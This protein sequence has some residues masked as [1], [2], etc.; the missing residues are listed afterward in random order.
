MGF[1]HFPLPPFPP[2]YLS[3]YVLYF[4]LTMPNYHD[5]EGVAAETNVYLTCTSSP[6]I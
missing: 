2:W 6:D 4:F 1:L 5:R 3:V